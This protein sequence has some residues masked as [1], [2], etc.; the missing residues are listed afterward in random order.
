MK[1]LISILLGMSFMVSCSSMSK[2][3]YTEEEIKAESTRINVFFEKEFKAGIQRYPT[4]LTYIGSRERYGELNDG[5]YEFAKEDIEL[6]KKSL[7]ELKKFNYAALDKQSKISYDLYKDRL[8]NSIK[9]FKYHYHGYYVNQMFGHHSSLPDFMINMHQIANKKEAQAYISRLK[10]FKKS[11]DQL[12]VNMKEQEKRGIKYPNFIFEKVIRDSQNVISGI[13]FDSSKKESALYEDFKRKLSKIKLKKT[14]KTILLN[15]AKIALKTSVKPSYEKLVTYLVDLEKR[16]P[17]SNGA[18]AFPGGAKFYKKALKDTT[19]TDMTATE[20][21]KT[22]LAEV[23]RIHDEMR[24]IMKE[25]KFEGSLEDF[26]KYMKASKRFYFSNN[27]KGR[28]AYLKETNKIIA[29]MKSKLDGL[30]NIKPKADLKV[31]PVEAFREKSAGIAFYQGPA[32]NGS[33][34]G[35]YY[36]N[37]SNMASVAKY[38]MEALAY[39]EAIP[40][41]HMQIAIAQE[42]KGIPTFRKMGGYTAYSEG[43]GLYSELVPKELGMYKDPYSDFGRLSMELWRACRLVVDTGIHYYKWDRDSSIAYLKKNTPNSDDE[44][45]KGVERYFVMPAQA[46]AYKVGQ[47]K[48]LSLRKYAKDNLKDKFDIKEFHDV[49]LKNGAL[50]MNQLEKQV[51]DYVATK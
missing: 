51:K 21:H 17:E 1:V 12:I 14:D 33:R 48:I 7:K 46:T 24:K 44:I 36:V 32:L 20:I 6:S 5:S 15:E 38:D 30:F 41:H 19:T 4:F 40:G 16:S 2:K 22:G 35:T 47:L 43:W 39:H 3:T 49:V 31:K 37:L 13:P 29:N 28:K 50:P 10:A 11:F 9:D 25:V 34:P 45:F 23:N 18:W 27:A 26:F 8:E 42:L